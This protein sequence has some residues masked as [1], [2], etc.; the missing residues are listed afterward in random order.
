MTTLT[1]S[2]TSYSIDPDHS[3]LGF[4]VRH[5]GISTFRGTLSGVRGSLRDGVLEGS[6]PIES[7]SVRTPAPLREHLLGDEFFSASAHPEVSFASDEISLGDDGSAVVRGRLTIRNISREVVATGTWQPPVEDPY[8]AVRS[9]LE[10]T[11]AI[12]RR[13]YGMTWNMPLPRGGDALG[14]EVTVSVQLE[15]IGEQA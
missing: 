1:A 9:A 14:H 5:M 6:A 10:L 15:L 7:I 3:A 13:D 8:G 2:T 12:D 11:A 4:S